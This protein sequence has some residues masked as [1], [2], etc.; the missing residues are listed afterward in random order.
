MK[1]H[2]DILVKGKVQGVHFRASARE[3]AR[4]LDIKGH[5]SNLPDGSVYCE[6]EGEENALQAFAEWCRRG[7]SRAQVTEAKITEGDIRLF[8]EFEIR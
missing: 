6:V 4:E 7:P 5:I 3:K 1:K 8:L 2:L